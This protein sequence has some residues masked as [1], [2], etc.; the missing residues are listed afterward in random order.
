MDDFDDFDE[1][2]RAVAQDL[3]SHHDAMLQ[4]RAELLVGVAHMH[5]P[6]P[7][8]RQLRAVVG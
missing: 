5:G 3:A 6:Q 1:F 4:L 8:V 7:A 2:V